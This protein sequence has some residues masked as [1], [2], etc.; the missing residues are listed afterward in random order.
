MTV[1]T[2]ALLDCGFERGQIDLVQGALVDRLV[3]AMALE[4]LVVCVEVFDGGNHA[5]ALDAV[6]VG[7]A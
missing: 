4:L 6:D 2:S 5:F 7:D 1:Q 3:D